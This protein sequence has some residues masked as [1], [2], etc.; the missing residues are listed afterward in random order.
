MPTTTMPEL[1][2]ALPSTHPS[3]DFLNA[4]RIR[5]S[6]TA[7]MLT[8]PGPSAAQL[9]DIL[10]I[11]SRVPD[12]RRVCPYRF[13]L[14]TGDARCDFGEKLKEVY[15]QENAAADP[16]LAEV[17]KNRFLR[18]PTIVALIYSPNLEHRTPVWE[19]Q[20]TVGAVGQNILLA[21]SSSGF[22][23][24]WLTEWYAFNAEI[25]RVLGLAE[26][27]QVA[28]YFY[29]GTAREEPRERARVDA[30]SITTNWQLG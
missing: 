24:Q 26:H 1:G 13:M 29:I 10:Q 4:L 14:F 23:A 11:A 16:S 22:A 18:A 15:L 12:H 2:D 5:R 3:D 7:A 27:E 8:T 9:E 6:T 19:Q 25:N 17:E 21:A 30:R 20:L 28:G